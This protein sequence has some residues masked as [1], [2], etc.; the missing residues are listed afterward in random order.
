MYVI[1]HIEEIDK[2]RSRPVYE[3]EHGEFADLQSAKKKIDEL[4]VKDGVFRYAHPKDIIQ[5]N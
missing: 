2:I 5:Q 4:R 3:F 1:A